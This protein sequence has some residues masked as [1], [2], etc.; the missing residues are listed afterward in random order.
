MQRKELTGL[1]LSLC[2]G[3]GVG[4]SKPIVEYLIVNQAAH[5]VMIEVGL[6]FL[7]LV[8]TIFLKAYRPPLKVFIALVFLLTLHVCVLVHLFMLPFVT[9]KQKPAAIHYVKTYERT[10]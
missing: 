5:I 4:L 7:C 6:F 10:I 3:S 1:Q 8:C 9:K 2:I